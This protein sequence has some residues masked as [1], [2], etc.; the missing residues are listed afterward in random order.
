M[1]SPS[2]IMI[3]RYKETVMTIYRTGDPERDI[4]ERMRTRDQYAKF[5]SD[6]N[7]SMTV[8][9]LNMRARDRIDDE[10]TELAGELDR[11]AAKRALEEA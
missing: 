2:R 11:Y 1:P 9:I 5:A 6:P 8:R 4:K 10:I 7:L 3:R